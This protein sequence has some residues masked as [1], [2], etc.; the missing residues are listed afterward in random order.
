[1][2]KISILTSIIFSLLFVW[3]GVFAD[4]G[5]LAVV[6]SG[7]VQWS[8]TG[9]NEW[10]DP[11]YIMNSANLNTMNSYIIPVKNDI[12]PTSYQELKYR[13]VKDPAATFGY[14]LKTDYNGSF[15][16]KVTQ[17]LRLHMMSTY[18]AI[19]F[20][21]LFILLFRY[22]GVTRKDTFFSQVFRI[23]YENVWNFF[24][25]VV[26][27]KQPLWTKHFVVNMFF[28]IL[29]ANLFGLVN[30][31][32]RFAFPQW[33]RRVT[34]PTG[35][36]EFNIALAVIATVVTLY[37][38]GVLVGWPHKLLHE[39]IPITGKWV[40]DRTSVVWV[41]WDILISLFMGVLDMVWLFA[42]IISLSLRLF[43]NMSSWSI[44]LNVIFVGLSWVT[45]W[46]IGLNMQIW[47][48]IAI[49]LQWLLA[50]VIQAF[51]FGLLTAM[52]IRLLNE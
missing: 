42:K 46:L 9:T 15:K 35:E 31:I 27:E 30:D 34:A 3:T 32:I 25:D 5:S 16:D 29:I 10:K 44:L 47:L 40:M 51:V 14:S 17:W 19:I 37:Y 45:V 11:Y 39:Y 21:F 52:G 41:F 38:Q 49:Y 36:F 50:A 7:V 22:F 43:G 12:D 20:M 26:G 33:L 18:P 48:P 2:K 8:T 23:L 6:E 24:A 4:T 1:M 28:V 13:L